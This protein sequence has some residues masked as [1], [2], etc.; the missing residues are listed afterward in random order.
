MKLVI[1]N[2]A[3]VWGGNEKWVLTLAEGLLAR[4]HEVVASCRAESPLA[5]ELRA[6]GVR[7]CGVRPGALLDLPRA[8]RFAW[9]LWRE[10][11]DAVLLTS[12]RST[13]WGARAARR[14][15]ARVVARLG[16]VRVPGRGA[17]AFAFRRWVDALVVN[18]AEIRE[19]WA[20]A[21]AWFPASRIHVVLNG[22][23]PPD[24]DRA[25]A[26]ARLR[27]ELGVSWE[28]LLLG[29]AGHLTRRKGFD[30][31]LEA[32]ARAALPHARL[33]VAGEGPAL[34]ELRERAAALGVGERV[35]WLGHRD[36]VPR[37]LAGCDLFVLSSRN[38]GMANVMLEAMAAG[39][40]V[41]ATGVSGVRTAL[42]ADG[43]QPPAGWIV[44]PGDPD[45]LATALREV[46]AQLR[47]DPAAV[48]ARVEHALRRVEQR[49]APERMVAEVEAVLG[50]HRAALPAPAPRGAPSLVAL[51]D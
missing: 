50:G 41:V 17:A 3:R 5:R 42:G 39:T 16:I 25:A 20:G 19:A 28:T 22:V 9:W 15:G 7:L 32:F 8:V 6:A 24:G 51:G 23:H 18:A 10:R 27:R 49:F 29:G 13:F 36:D 30:L 48:G 40:P 26:G 12:W 1:Q 35:H 34:A 38:E 11:P 43:D 45:A 33:V 44:P 21:A 37:V 47:A 14:A 31:L 46:A 2:S 4:G